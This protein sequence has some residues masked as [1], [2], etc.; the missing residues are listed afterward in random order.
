MAREDGPAEA[1]SE[2]ASEW[3]DEAVRVVPYDPSWPVRFEQERALLAAALGEWVVGGIHHVGSTAIPGLGA[4]PIIDILVGVED[5][6]ASRAC[7]PALGRL[8]YLY[9]PYR[10][11]EM[12]W[13]CK[14][15]PSRRT[16]HL[17]L[18][19]AHSQRFREELVFRDRLRRAPNLAR[20]YA[21]LKRRLAVQFEHDRDAYT[22]A[23]TDFIREVLAQPS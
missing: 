7:F 9:A 10:A 22:D 4:K 15:H 1:P 16:H 13:F 3:A 2:S 6:A 17:H 11:D 19:P 8:G 20:E 21:R 12:H 18:V 14:P 23:K 5:L